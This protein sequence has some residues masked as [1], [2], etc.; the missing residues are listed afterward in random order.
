VEVSLTDKELE[1]AIKFAAFLHPKANSPDNE[2]AVAASRLTALLSAAKGPGVARSQRSRRSSQ[3]PEPTRRSQERG[4]GYRKKTRKKSRLRIGEGESVPIVMVGELHI[5]VKH[6]LDQVPKPCTEDDLCP[7]CEGGHAP[8]KSYIVNA[9]D[10][11][12]LT[13]KL[14]E[15]SRALMRE[16]LDAFEGVDDVSTRTATISRKGTGKST[17]WRVDIGA[18]A[19]KQQVADAEKSADNLDKYGRKA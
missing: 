5:V 14:F 17:R 10:M 3:R 6:W 16:F 2:R 18:G 8:T 15:F 1:R 19:T 11:R 7:Y 13:V 12:D 9:L 4:T